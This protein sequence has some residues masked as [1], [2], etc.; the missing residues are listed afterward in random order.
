[1]THAQAQTHTH[2]HTHTNWDIDFLASQTSR[3]CI[4]PRHLS[5]HQDKTYASTIT[6]FEWDTF[7]L[8]V[9][10]YSPRQGSM[11]LYPRVKVSLTRSLSLCRCFYSITLKQEALTLNVW[12]INR[13]C[14]AVWSRLKGILK[15]TDL[16]VLCKHCCASNVERATKL[17][18][19]ALG[20]CKLQFTWNILKHSCKHSHSLSQT[21]RHPIHTR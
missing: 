4:N 8:H 1:M 21:H 2:T 10:S 11:S 15:T 3:A 9:C 18:H 20:V 5:H 16:I 6:C 19:V 7:S 17:N 14:Q 12:E 13:I